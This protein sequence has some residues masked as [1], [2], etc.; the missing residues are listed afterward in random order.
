MEIASLL[1]AINKDGITI[2]ELDQATENLQFDDLV[3]PESISV[4]NT[5][6]EINSITKRLYELHNKRKGDPIPLNKIITLLEL[7]TRIVGMLNIKPDVQNIIDS[8]INTYK[9][10]FLDL[11]TH[12]VDKVTMEVL[13]QKLNSEGL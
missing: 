11:A 10:R 12:C 3:I 4:E 7:K 9:R 2:D 5:L 6:T 1:E 13:V 8:E